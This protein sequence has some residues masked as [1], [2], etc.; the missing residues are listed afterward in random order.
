M[1]KEGTLLV[2]GVL[3][4]VSPFLGLPMSWLT[5]LLPIL[6]AIVITISQIIR[7][8]RKTPSMRSDAASSAA[9]R[10]VPVYDAPSPIA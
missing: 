2:V 9:V 8:E 5:F 7:K 10:E 4:L 3:V 6:G 1:S